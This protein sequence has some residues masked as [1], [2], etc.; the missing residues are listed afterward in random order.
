[1]VCNNKKQSKG[2][3][4][5]LIITT[6][7]CDKAQDCEGNLHCYSDE[8]DVGGALFKSDFGRGAT[9]NAYPGCTTVACSY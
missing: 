5:R 8:D 1:M 6:T 9:N 3:N 2:N 7:T 4:Q